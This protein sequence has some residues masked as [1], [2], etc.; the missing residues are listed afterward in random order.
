[1]YTLPAVA[2]RVLELTGSDQP[3]LRKIRD[4]IEVDPALAGRILRIANSSFFGLPA[5][6]KDLPQA[7]GLLGARTLTMLVLGFNLPHD[8]TRGV[9]PSVLQRFWRLTVYRAIAARA[10]AQRHWQ[11]PGD[12]AFLAG[13]LDGIGVLAL[14]QDLGQ[15]YAQ[16]LDH[17]Y[18]LGADLAEQELEV[19]GFD[20]GVLAARMLEQWNLPASLIGAVGRPRQLERVLHL[21]LDQQPVAGALHL[22]DLAAEFLIAGQRARLQALLKAGG[23]LKS[24][25]RESIQ[26]LLEAVEQEAT[27]LAELFEVPLPESGTVAQLFVDAHAK[28]SELTEV[29]LGTCDHDR[30]LQN[31]LRDA[32]DMQQHARSAAEYSAHKGEHLRRRSDAAPTVSPFSQH[33]TVSLSGSET[34]LAAR[35]AVAIERCRADRCSLS[36]ALATIENFANLQIELGP[37]RAAELLHWLTRQ[38]CTAGDEPTSVLAVGDGKLAILLEGYDRSTAAAAAWRLLDA[39][40]RHVREASSAS[41]SARLSLGVASVALPP[42]NFAEQQLIDAARRCVQAARICGSDTVKSIET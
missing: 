10:F 30:D 16:F 39:F 6:V 5:E 25:S 9:P 32:A 24:L 20:H 34:S 35:V 12:D 36:L 7:L 3:D 14:I 23:E 42:R 31:I 2:A 18:D 33:Q 37:Q 15:T 41:T 27:Q 21:P 38:S 8:L 26:S 19:L 22:A 1:L 17:V 4:C 40:R 29:M 13:I 28:L 11:L